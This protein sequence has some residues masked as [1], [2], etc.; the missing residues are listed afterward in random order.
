MFSHLAVYHWIASDSHNDSA[1][2]LTALA[3]HHDDDD[4]DV[5]VVA[6]VVGV[7]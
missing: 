3:W 6:V 2:Q 1:M 4:D 7:G 5:V